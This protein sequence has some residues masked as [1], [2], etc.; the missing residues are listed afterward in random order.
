MTDKVNAYE[1]SDLQDECRDRGI[2]YNDA[3][4]VE[5]LR[6]RLSPK[7]PKKEED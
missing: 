6:E 3:K 2:P 5:E 1:F 7:K 4:S